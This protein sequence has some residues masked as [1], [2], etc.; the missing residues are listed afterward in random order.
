MNQHPEPDTTAPPTL[1]ERILKHLV[2]AV[3]DE[4]ARCE[5]NCSVSECSHEEW[6]RCSR[7][8]LGPATIPEEK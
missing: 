4:L 1:R 5:F 2:Q 7:R 6:E 3:P 8:R